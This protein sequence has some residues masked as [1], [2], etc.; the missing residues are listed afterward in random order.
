MAVQRRGQPKSWL[1][2]WTGSVCIYS[3]CGLSVEE[4]TGDCN[5]VNGPPAGFQM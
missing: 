5:L 2:V 3:C 1:E 4:A